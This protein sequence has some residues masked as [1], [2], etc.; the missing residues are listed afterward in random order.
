MTILDDRFENFLLIV[1]IWIGLWGISD[2]ILGLLIPENNYWIR[3]II[4]IVITVF[5]L[6][7]YIIQKE[8]YLKQV[9]NNVKKLK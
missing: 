8:K 6:S 5:S 4:Y 7:L 1:L 9:L 2:N 3:L